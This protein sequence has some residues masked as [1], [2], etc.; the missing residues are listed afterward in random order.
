MILDCGQQQTIVR[1]GV[2]VV[3]ID[4]VAGRVDQFG[5]PEIAVTD[6]H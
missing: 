6:W 4:S 2:R 3:R 1:I 5:D